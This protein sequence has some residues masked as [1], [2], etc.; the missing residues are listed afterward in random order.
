M[1]KMEKTFWSQ[2]LSSFSIINPEIR[3]KL[4]EIKDKTSTLFICEDMYGLYLICIIKKAKTK[5]IARIIW[6]FISNDDEVKI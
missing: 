5:I 3:V 1:I 4:A 6:E 2:E